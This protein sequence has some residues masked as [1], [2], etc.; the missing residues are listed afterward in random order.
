ML[1]KK[2]T[3]AFAFLQ[4]K[5]TYIV[6]AIGVLLAILA[7]LNGEANIATTLV[8]IQ[9]AVTGSTVRA[10]SKSDAKAVI[11][12]RPSSDAAAIP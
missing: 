11:E 9:I 1:M 6:S 8:A 2:I 5:K 4:G 7:Y 10:G 3:D 12:S